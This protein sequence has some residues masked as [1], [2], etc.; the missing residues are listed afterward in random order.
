MFGQ[1]FLCRLRIAVRPF[2]LCTAL[3]APSTMSGSDPLTVLSLPFGGAYLGLAP[4]EPSG[5]PKFLTL[6][7]THTTLF[8][9]PDRPS[10]SSPKR[11]LCVGFWCVK[12]IAV[13][14]SRA[15]GAVSSFGECGLSCGLRGALCTLHLARS[16]FTSSTGATLGRSGW[17]DLAP[18]GLAPCKKRQAS[19]GA[20]TLALTC[21][22][23]RERR[24]SGR[25]RQSGAAPDCVKTQCFGRLSHC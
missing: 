2:P 20:L 23:K 21:C 1:C 5:S 9:D 10:G 11:F 17:L 22:R 12:T 4:Q 6:L 7:S 8:V 18:Q 13:C 25:W 3:P 16:V 24:R 14:M 15:N 19:L